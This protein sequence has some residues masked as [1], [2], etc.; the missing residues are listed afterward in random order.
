MDEAAGQDCVLVF[1][2]T[3]VEITAR[4][5]ENMLE[6]A[7]RAGVIVPSVCR[8]GT[9]GTCRVLL[10]SGDPELDT[11]KALSPKQRRA[12]WILAC[13]ARLRPG[14]TVVDA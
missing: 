2:I 4:A 11:T 7:D 13:S 9:C 3:G 5:G 12:G 10:R 1:K 6:V 8:G 14:R